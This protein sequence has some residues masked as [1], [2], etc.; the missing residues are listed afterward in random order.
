MTLSLKSLKQCLVHQPTLQHDQMH[1]APPGPMSRIALLL[2]LYPPRREG[3]FKDAVKQLL[4]QPSRAKSVEYPRRLVL[5]IAASLSSLISQRHQRRWSKRDHH[6]TK[7][8]SFIICLPL[9]VYRIAS[10]FGTERLSVYAVIKSRIYIQDVTKSSI[11]R[12]TPKGWSGH[13]VELSAFLGRTSLQFD[14]IACLL[15]RI[16]RGD[17][18]A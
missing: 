6:D 18:R 10:C 12:A 13:F 17:V 5:R 15:C 3:M 2:L 7:Q 1:R 11:L 9:L 4:L 8:A 16:S 14:C